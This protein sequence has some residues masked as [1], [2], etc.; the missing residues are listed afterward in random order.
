LFLLQIKSRQD[1]LSLSVKFH[2]IGVNG[3]VF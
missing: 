3:M 1:L 2:F